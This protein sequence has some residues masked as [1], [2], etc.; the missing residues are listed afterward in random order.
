MILYVSALFVDARNDHDDVASRIACSTKLAVNTGTV[1]LGVIAGTMISRSK[2]EFVPSFKNKRITFAVVVPVAT[3]LKS[4]TR[5]PL[6][7]PV[8]TVA[9]VPVPSLFVLAVVT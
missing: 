5:E 2:R 7:P 1:V 8:I 4:S 6:E 9:M 3:I